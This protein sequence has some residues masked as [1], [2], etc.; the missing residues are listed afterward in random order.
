MGD[1]TGGGFR[2]GEEAAFVGAERMRQFFRSCEVVPFPV[3]IRVSAEI[4]CGEQTGT[5][6]VAK[7]AKSVGHP[8]NFKSRGQECPRHTCLGHTCSS[9][10]GSN[11]ANQP[12]DL[13][14]VTTTLSRVVNRIA[15]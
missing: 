9:H 7:D 6:L 14:H 5:H 10:T 2:G 15:D 13:S 8:V 12:E 4:C 1:G 3:P 11:I